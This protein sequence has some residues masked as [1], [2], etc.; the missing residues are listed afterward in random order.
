[1][2]SSSKDKEEAA[3]AAPS[4]TAPNQRGLLKFNFLKATKPKYGI[5]N[6]NANRTT[7]WMSHNSEDVRYQVYLKKSKEGYKM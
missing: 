2:S 4:L 1:M 6:I 3:A 5:N 7:K